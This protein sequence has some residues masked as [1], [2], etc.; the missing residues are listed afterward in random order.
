MIALASVLVALLGCGNSEAPAPAT[1]SATPALRAPDAPP[2]ATPPPD[3]AA[4]APVPT[5]NKLYRI[6]WRTLPAPPPLSTLFEIEA[7]VTDAA[8]AP[9][10]NASVRIDARM[11]Q[12]GHGMATR[13]EDDRGVCVDTVCTHPGGLYRTRGMKFHMPGEWTLRFDVEGPAGA[14]SLE[15]PV[16]I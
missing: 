9:V 4:G 11:P 13:P 15:V 2:D 7:T 3:A 12:H 10:E 14:D 6:A 16:R 5:M 8:G 1:P